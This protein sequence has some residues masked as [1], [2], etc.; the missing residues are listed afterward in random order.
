MKNNVTW[1]V[2]KYTNKQNG[3]CYIGI[4]SRTL[5][6]RAGKD[7]KGYKRKS[8]GKFWEAIQKYGWDSFVVE[9]LE[10][11]IS[12]RKVALELES[13]HIIESN[14]IENGYNETSDTSACAKDKTWKWNISEERKEEI[15]I[16]NSKK[17]VCGGI[18]YNGVEELSKKC[19]ISKGTIYGWLGRNKEFV[20]YS[21]QREYYLKDLGLKYYDDLS[22][23]GVDKLKL[24]LNNKKLLNDIEIREKRIL[25]D[26]ELAS[27]YTLINELLIIENKENTIT[28]NEPSQYFYLKNVISNILNL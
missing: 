12:E 5:K 11:D 23:D 17:V 20:N 2:Y 10:N 1:K 8:G 4:T 25:I 26:K 7:G 21:E 9:I 24:L 16:E 22:Q 15:K 6:E 14:A 18:I 28:K 3:M 13:K 27:I 19:G